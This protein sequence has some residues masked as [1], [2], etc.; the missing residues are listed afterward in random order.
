MKR[1][2]NLHLRRLN[3]ELQSVSASYKIIENHLEKIYSLLNAF[4]TLSALDQLFIP[5]DLNSFMEPIHAVQFSITTHSFDWEKLQRW[6]LGSPKEENI[7]T[8]RNLHRRELQSSTSKASRKRHNAEEF[9][10]DND[11]EIEFELNQRIVCIY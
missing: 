1:Q 5:Q 6:I 4:D 10:E 7:S 8:K 9:E 11:E 3:E 2:H